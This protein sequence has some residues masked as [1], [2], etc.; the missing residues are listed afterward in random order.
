MKANLTAILHAN[1][2][3]DLTIYFFNHIIVETKIIKKNTLTIY[4][5][6]FEV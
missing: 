4:W 2:I 6:L 5:Y 1:N 3:L